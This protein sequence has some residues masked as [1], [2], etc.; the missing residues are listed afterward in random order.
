MSTDTGRPRAATV[1]PE[2]LPDDRFLDRE[3]SWL[4]F[5]ERVLELAEDDDAAA[6]RARQV[7]RDLRQQ[8]RRVLHGARGRP[9]APHRHRHRRARRQRAACRARCSRRSTHAARELMQRQ[10]DRLP[11]RGAARARRTRASSCCAGTSLDRRRARPAQPASS[12]P[13]SSRCSRRWPSTPRTRSPTSRASRS[14]S[15]SSCATRAPAPSSS[16]ASRCRRSSPRFVPVG[17]QR[18]VPLEDVI[19]AHLGE[20]FPGMEVLQHHT[21]RVTRNEDL[22]VEEDDAENLLLGA[23]ARADAPPVRAAGAARGRGVDRPARARPARARARHRHRG[24]LPPPRAARPHRR[25]G[26]STGLAARR[27]QVPGVPAHARSRELAD[28]E[29]VV[30]A[31]RVRGD[32]RPRRAAAPPVRLVLHQRA[33][34]PRAGRGRPARARDQAD[35]LPHQ[36]R[37]P[38]R[39]RPH[40]RR[41]GGQAGARDR[42]D[43]G[44]LRRA[45]QHR[46]GAQA[47]AGRLPRRLR[48]R[49][50]QDPL[51]ALDGGARRRRRAAPLHPH[52]HRQLPPQDR[53]ALRGPRPAHHRRGGRRGRRPTCSTS[54]PATRWRP[55]TTGC[56]S[57]RTR[58]APGWSSGSSAR[59]STTGPGVPA[60]IRIKCN[61]IVDEAHHRRALP[62]VAGGR[63]G[64]HLGARHLR[65]APRRTRAV[66][67]DP[68]AHRA[69]PLP[70][71]LAAST[72]STT[73]ASPRCGSAR[74][75][76]CTATS[77]AASRCSCGSGPP[78]TS[79][80]LSDLLDLAFDPGTSTWHLGA[81]GAGRAVDRAADGT[82]LADVQ[83]TLIARQSRRSSDG[84]L[85]S[86][87]GTTGPIGAVDPDL[88][89]PPAVPVGR[90]STA[91]VAVMAHL[92]RQ[93]SAP[94]RRRRRRRRRATTDAVHATRVAAR[95]LRAGLRVYGDLL[96]ATTS[97]ARLRPEL[98]VVRRCAL[99]AARPRG[100]SPVA[101]RRAER[102]P[103]ASRDALAARGC[104]V[105]ATELARSPR[106]GTRSRSGRR[107]TQLRRGPGDARPRAPRFT[108]AAGRRAPKVLAPRVLRADRAR[109]PTGSSE[110]RPATTPSDA[111]HAARITAKRARYAAE[112][113][114][115]R[116]SGR[117]P[118]RPGRALVDAHRPARRGA[119]RRDPAR[120][121]C[122]TASTTP[123]CRCPPARRSPAASFVASHATTARSQAHLRASRGLWSASRDEHRGCAGP[124]SVAR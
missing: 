11:R 3:L 92:R 89:L 8:P 18:F 101:R 26:R 120:R 30:A 97:P 49:R 29:T 76:S 16:P 57:P 45:G 111:W 46:L 109:R 98:V 86:G 93:T 62:R 105:A 103:T 123:R 40:R 124:W 44:A 100:A 121:S 56:S 14:T 21:F 90:D 73:A 114:R 66:G 88:V 74:P 110:L 122:S 84:V 43:Q 107:A 91:G 112:V 28:V 22:E 58:C 27:P 87:D 113:G 42:R 47:R 24:G 39:R 7:P 2:P 36:R 50:P 83:A 15:P 35:A 71:A 51:Q 99:A 25:C 59:S 78:S 94:A 55:S 108:A 19:A 60:R 61:S 80:E 12:A 106:V 69:R 85:I 48:P 53:P 96:D 10:A 63:A 37:L 34:L 70:R 52:R 75:T 4:A 5:N 6:A 118:Q 64:R 67:D 33:A 79:R 82:P 23:R 117:R 77:T 54:C 38:D 32:A 95:R 1:E 68:G 31:R 9:Q 81:D 115:S 65:A 102:R 116:R 13:R 104:A 72:G 17:P 20:L 41:R 119:G